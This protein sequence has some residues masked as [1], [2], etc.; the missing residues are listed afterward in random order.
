MTEYQALRSLLHVNYKIGL[1]DSYALSVFSWF[2]IIIMDSYILR[3]S[4]LLYSAHSLRT[5]PCITRYLVECRAPIGRR[6]IR[7]SVATVSAELVRTRISIGGWLFLFN[8]DSTKILQYLSLLF[9]AVVF[10]PLYIDT[11]HNDVGVTLILCNGQCPQLL[12]VYYFRALCA[13]TEGTR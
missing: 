8:G 10:L 5:K 11:N 6:P 12:S 2:N 1:G 7:A 4:G 9:S 13:M 3:K